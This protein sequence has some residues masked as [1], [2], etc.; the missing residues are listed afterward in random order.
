[1]A[2]HPPEQRC[3]DEACGRATPHGR[4]RSRRRLALAAEHGLELER[5]VAMP[6]NNLNVVFRRK[7]WDRETLAADRPAAKSDA[8]RS[9]IRAET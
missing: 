3:L 8:V 2:T 4:A 6:A 7:P 9:S 5:T 1:M